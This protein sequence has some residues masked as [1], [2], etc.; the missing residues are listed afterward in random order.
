VRY[1]ED[2]SWVAYRINPNAKW[3]D[4]EP[5]TAEDV[6]WSFNK[7]VELNPS[8]RFYYQHVTKAEVTGEREV[9][10]T[11]DQTGNRELPHIVGQLM[12]LPKHYWEGTDANGNKRDIAQGTLD[13]PLGSGPYRIASVVPGRTITY[14]RVPDAWAANLNVNVGSRRSRPAGSITGWRTR[15]SAGKPV[16][17]FRRSSPGRSRRS[18]WSSSR[19][20][21]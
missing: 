14:E 4:G 18:W 2:S 15:R 12:V 13:P 5:I 1:P 19:S 7:L 20:P 17:T 21:A 10:F 3:H 16:M 11:F 9:T 8:Q 6:V